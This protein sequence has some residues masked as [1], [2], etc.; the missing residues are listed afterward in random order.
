MQ[1]KRQRLSAQI[2]R[3]PELEKRVREESLRN[4]QKDR[5]SSVQSLESL[6]PST[7]SS[8]LQFN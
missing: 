4:F 2:D 7:L 3:R 1:P 5:I 6:I 8:E